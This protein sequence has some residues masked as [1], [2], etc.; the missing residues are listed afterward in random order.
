MTTILDVMIGTVYVYLFFSILC[1]G[2]TEW[3]SRLRKLRAR[4]LWAAMNKL[5]VRS[6]GGHFAKAFHSHP[7]IRNLTEKGPY[8]TYIPSLHFALAFMDLAI[9]F[10]MPQAPGAIPGLAKIKPNLNTDEKPEF[11]EPEKQLVNSLIS[12]LNSPG[13]VQTRLERW[14]NDAMERVSGWYKRKTY[15]TLLIVSLL[16]SLGFGVDTFRLANGLYRNNAVRE[17]I[18]KKAQVTLDKAT[19]PMKADVSLKDLAVPIGWSRPVGLSILGCLVTAFALTLG[20]PFWF[21]LLGRL[22][23]LRQTGVPPDLKGKIVAH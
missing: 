15:S 11:T 12:G 5:L 2:I 6:G 21:D 16:V 14:F 23:N 13:A 17:A 4:V 3:I 7:L 8:P 9:D 1:S 19:D 22:V 20:A 18:I 10:A